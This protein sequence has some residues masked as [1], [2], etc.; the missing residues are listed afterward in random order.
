M[1][2]AV[3]NNYVTSFYVNM[4]FHF[5]EISALKSIAGSYGS[6]MFS[7]VRNCQIVSQS[8]CVI[9]HPC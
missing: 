3:M 4:N 1:N 6:C 8:G 9:L 2:E 7:F 5:S